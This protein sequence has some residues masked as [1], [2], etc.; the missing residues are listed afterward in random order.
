MNKSNQKEVGL[1]QVLNYKPSGS[2]VVSAYLMV[3]GARTNKRD[4]LT[5]LNSMMTKKKD[6]LENSK[7]I[8]R[9]EK[10]KVYD[11]FEKIKKYVDDRFKADSAKTLLIYADSNNLWEVLSLPIVMRSKIIVD[12]KP[13][14]QNLRSMVQSFNKY[15]ILLMDRE[16]A[17]IYLL[18]L[19]QIKEYLAAFIND[20]PSK[21]NFRSEAAFREKKILGKIEE[22]LHH[23][24]KIINDKTL[25]LFNEE[26]FDY[27]ILAGRKEILSNFSNYLHN[28]LESKMIG[29]IEAQPDTEVWQIREKAQELI[30]QYEQKTRDDL[31]HNLF[32]EYNPNGWA[33]I[34]VK[35]TIKALLIEQIRT[36]I[37]DRN[38]IQEGYVCDSCQYITIDKQDQCPYCDGN[39]VYY[40]D[41]ID[42]IVEDALAQGCEVVDVEDNSRLQQAGGIAAIL[43][44]KL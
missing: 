34:G 13:H 39:L 10:K 43:R 20:V 4:Y 37:Y 15:A 35:A 7:D 9:D 19:G 31:V 33:V 36:L 8:P 30:D 5:K 6:E 2:P 32:E 16:K 12:P 21:V 1:S 28:Y 23:F 25:E 17:Q 42:E 22:K 3:D 29:Q 38:L 11:I 26:K 44:Y 40:N 24:F 27:L 41:I 14:T 18:Y